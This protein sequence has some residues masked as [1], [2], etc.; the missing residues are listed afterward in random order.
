MT[1]L[2]E[3][4]GFKLFATNCV[5]GK[6]YADDYEK[7]VQKAETEVAK[8][9]DFEEVVEEIKSDLRTKYDRK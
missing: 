8:G 1:N 3:E 6:N 4:Q 7:C 9:K 2:N 5:H